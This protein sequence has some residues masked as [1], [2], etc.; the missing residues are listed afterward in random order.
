M[1]RPTVHDIA[2]EAGVIVTDEHW[3]RRWAEPLTSC[4]RP[5]WTMFWMATTSSSRSS[6]DAFTKPALGGVLT[7]GGHVAGSS[8]KERARASGARGGCCR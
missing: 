4:A 5:S 2:K 1:I 6:I 7:R 3:Q 8:L